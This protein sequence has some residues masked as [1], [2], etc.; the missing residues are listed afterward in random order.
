[1]ICTV[2][3]Q[4]FSPY[5]PRQSRFTRSTNFCGLLQNLFGRNF[6]FFS[7]FENRSFENYQ[8]G[9]YPMKGLKENQ[10]IEKLLLQDSIDK[11]KLDINF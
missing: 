4:P 5:F 10:M 9:F 1:M 3:L 11:V 6:T 2:C 8:V 7:V